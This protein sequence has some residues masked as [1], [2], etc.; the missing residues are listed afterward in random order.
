MKRQEAMFTWHHGPIRRTYSCRGTTRG[1][2]HRLQLCTSG[3]LL[4]PLCHMIRHTCSTASCTISNEPITRQQVIGF[5]RV[6]VSFQGQIQ[7]LSSTYKVK[8]FQH[9]FDLSD[10]TSKSSSAD[11]D[12]CSPFVKRLPYMHV[13]HELNTSQTFRCANVN[14]SAC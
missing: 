11:F 10:E 4:K 3:L 5:N 8:L 9:M 6:Y 14:K 12:L 1:L 13:V 7:G 2:V